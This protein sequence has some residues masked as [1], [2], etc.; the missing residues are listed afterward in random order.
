MW[1]VGNPP[2]LLRI[3]L[4]RGKSWFGGAVLPSHSFPSY[5]IEGEMVFNYRDVGL[6]THI[7]VLYA[8]DFLIN[9]FSNH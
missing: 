4:L 2:D 5:L 8:F 3:G 1:W 7:P 6:S 9:V